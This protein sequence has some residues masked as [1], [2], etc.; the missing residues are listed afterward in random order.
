MEDAEF[1]VRCSGEPV[2]WACGPR[3]DALREAYHYSLIYAHDRPTD[4]WEVHK[5]YT[6]VDA[7]PLDYTDEA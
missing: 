3:T 4:I 5:T 2:A 7:I 6:R 1:E